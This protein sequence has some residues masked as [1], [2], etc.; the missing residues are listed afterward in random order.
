MTLRKIIMPIRQARHSSVL[1]KQSGATLVVAL[2]F[3]VIIVGVSLTSIQTTSIE[4]RMASNSRERNQAFQAAETGLREAE[5]FI[6]TLVTTSSFGTNAGLLGASDSEPDY[7][8]S[9]IWIDANSIQ[10]TSGAV[11]TLSGIDEY[12]RYIIKYV[13][14]NSADTDESLSIDGYGERLAGESATIFKI[15]SRGVG[16]SSNSQVVLQTHYGK[17]F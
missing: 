1:N 9:S 10:V 6:N 15:T 14:E 5:Q 12:P 17:R 8:D 4:E 3:L 13:V 2:I 11:G 16:G 7:F